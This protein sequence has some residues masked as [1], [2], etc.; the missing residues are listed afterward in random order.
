MPSEGCA[1]HPVRYNSPLKIKMAM[2]RTFFIIKFE[3]AGLGV[4]ARFRQECMFGALKM[5]QKAITFCSR[6]PHPTQ[7][8]SLQRAGGPKGTLRLD[9]HRPIFDLC[10]F[11]NRRCHHKK[12]E[13]GCKE[14]QVKLA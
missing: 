13:G 11:L 7:Q 2:W 14:I 1:A 9:S 3:L 4:G 6:L 8:N 5:R 12:Q 10:I